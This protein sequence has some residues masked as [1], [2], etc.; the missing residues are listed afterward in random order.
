MW[1]APATGSSCNAA[2]GWKS[3]GPSTCNY[4]GLA[5]A[6][7]TAN[8][9]IDLPSGTALSV[10]PAYKSNNVAGYNTS[11]VPQARINSLADALSS[12]AN[13]T[14]GSSANCGSLFGDA[15]VGTSVPADTLQATLNI[16][17]NPG[18]NATQIASLAAANASFPSALT[19]TQLFCS[20]G[21]G[22]AHHLSGGG[23]RQYHNAANRHGGR[24][25]GEYLDNAQNTSTLPTG[26]GTE[27]GG[28]VALF[29]NQGAPLSPSAT[30]ADS[31]GGYVSGVVNPQAI[32]IDQNGFAWIGN[33]ASQGSTAGSITV[34]DK[35]GT[36]QY[37]TSTPYTPR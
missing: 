21:L 6:F 7:A 15:T 33:Y 12:C 23:D 24:W 20:H 8:N 19:S 3:T 11:I 26:T 18:N 10:T 16:A 34:L 30:S 1:G 17:Q 4:I 32:A 2:G 14:T 13:P 5:N 9:L 25:G 29:S 28:L 36:P 35:T 31:I 22:I 37:G 27:T